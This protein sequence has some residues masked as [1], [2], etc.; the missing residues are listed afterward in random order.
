MFN[1]GLKLNFSPL[2]SKCFSI[3]KTISEFFKFFLLLFSAFI[4]NVYNKSIPLLLSILR[5]LITNWSKVYRIF[6]FLFKLAILLIFAGIFTIYRTFILL[7]YAL[8]RI[9]D[10]FFLFFS[11]S[12]ISSFQFLFFSDAL[13]LNFRLFS[14]FSPL[15]IFHLR[16]KKT[17]KRKEKRK[18]WN[19]FFLIKTFEEY[20]NLKIF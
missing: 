18:I 10:F 3:S 16:K 6:H 11:Y 8:P 2:Y 19:K 17:K 1:H 20:W 4:Y 14:N 12:F 9:L 7:F 13:P 5:P 15:V